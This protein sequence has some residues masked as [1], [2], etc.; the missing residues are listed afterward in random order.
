MFDWLVILLRECYENS[1]Y[2]ADFPTF[3]DYLADLSMI[4]YTPITLDLPRCIDSSTI[5]TSFQIA[6]GSRSGSRR[7]YICPRPN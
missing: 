6:I 2:R 4:E 1:S 3:E 5:V 7:D